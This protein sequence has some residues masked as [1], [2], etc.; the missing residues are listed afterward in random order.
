[1]EIEIEVEQHIDEV[2]KSSPEDLARWAISQAGSPIGALYDLQGE[3]DKQLGVRFR[4]VES[5][6]TAESPVGKAS[7]E[8]RRLTEELSAL[9]PDE[10]RKKY[11]LE[12]RRAE[13]RAELSRLEQ[14]ANVERAKRC[15]GEIATFIRLQNDQWFR[16]LVTENEDVAR[17]ALAQLGGAR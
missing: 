4:E 6:I 12:E 5:L 7:E 8:L 16:A 10:F 13:L 15:G 14:A 11:E 2:G 9:K 3:V 17:S 1:M